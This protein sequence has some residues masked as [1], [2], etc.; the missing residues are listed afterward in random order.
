VAAASIGQVH[1]AQLHDGRDLAIKVQYPGVARS[2]DSDVAN[3]GALIRMSGLLPKGFELRPYLAE[4]ARQLHEETDY[5]REGGCLKRFA[6]LLDGTPGFVLPQV[7]AD[8]STGSILAMDFIEGRPIE[9]AATL[10]QEMR[11]AIMTRLIDLMLKEIFSFRL[12]QSDPNFANYRF[13]PE[14]GDVILLDFGATRELSD[15]ISELYR[16]FFVSGLAGNASELEEVSTSIGFISE[17]MNSSHRR[18][19]L[20]LIRIA[21]EA[22]RAPIFDF[23]DRSLTQRMQRGG[24]ALARDG[25]VPP[26]LPMDVLYL[27]RKFGGMFLMGARLKV[28]L[29]VADIMRAH[30]AA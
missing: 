10:P 5:A 19:A 8:W 20:D 17:N 26:V 29:P 12:M 6:Q 24:E 23:T 2:I 11:E 14:S 13:D 21:F 18:Q 30:L 25:F 9:E 27:Q 16:K 15:E 22:L 4:A 3:V 7:H 28:R 1:R